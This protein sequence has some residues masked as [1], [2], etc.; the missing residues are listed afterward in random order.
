[1]S[2]GSCP[3][4]PP[5]ARPAQSPSPAPCWALDGMASPDGQH[6][7]ILAQQ[8]GW[9]TSWVTR[10]HLAPVASHFVLEVAH[11]WDL[12]ALGVQLSLPH[13]TFQPFPGS[14]PSSCF[15]LRKCTV[16]FPP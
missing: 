9:P 5:R 6:A 11:S 3:A 15:L 13:L 10:C 4:C 2:E 14:W 7:V 16:G 1:M 8:T 12:L